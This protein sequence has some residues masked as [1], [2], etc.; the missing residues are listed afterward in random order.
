MCTERA[1]RHATRLWLLQPARQKTRN[2]T[3]R[4][5]L[6]V[7]GLAGCEAP[8]CRLGA[9]LSGPVMVDQTRFPSVRSMRS[10]AQAANKAPYLEGPDLSVPGCL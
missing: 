2:C 4:Y 8:N 6:A 10:R 7:A 9:S 1:T 5:G 3:S